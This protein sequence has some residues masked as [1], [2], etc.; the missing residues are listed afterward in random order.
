MPQDRYS[1]STY[2]SNDLSPPCG[3]HQT[4]HQGECRTELQDDDEG[5]TTEIMER[6]M[7]GCPDRYHYGLL[8]LLPRRANRRGGRVH[9]LPLS[10]T[11]F[12]TWSMHIG[13]G[14]DYQ[15]RKRQRERK[16]RCRLGWEKREGTEDS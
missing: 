10:P 14:K 13:A 12:L 2:L 7:S 5:E 6:L 11:G 8:L 9:V 4:K 3:R 16:G 15:Q 1:I